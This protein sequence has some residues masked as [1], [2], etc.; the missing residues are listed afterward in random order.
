MTWG[1]A[2]SVRGLLVMVPAAAQKHRAAPVSGVGSQELLHRVPFFLVWVVDFV[3]EGDVVE[4]SGLLDAEPWVRHHR[5][6]QVLDIWA[7]T[8]AP[9]PCVYVCLSALSTCACQRCLR[10]LVSS[11]STSP[12]TPS[13]LICTHA[14]IHTHTHET[15]RCTHMHHT[16]HTHASHMELLHVLPQDLARCSSACNTPPTHISHHTPLCRGQTSVQR[17]VTGV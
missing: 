3:G 2:A 14:H 13:H 5:L 8:L 1:T 7:H 6:V 11:S 10:V 16:L 4:V 12:P 9:D 17:S 15:C